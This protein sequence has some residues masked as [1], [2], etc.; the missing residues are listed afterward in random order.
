MR[1][2]GRIFAS[3]EP[4][5][6]VASRDDVGRGGQRPRYLSRRGARRREWMSVSRSQ[7]RTGCSAAWIRVPYRARLSAAGSRHVWAE[8]V[9][10]DIWLVLRPWTAPT[11]SSLAANLTGAW[12]VTVHAEANVPASVQTRGVAQRRFAATVPPHT[13]TRHP[14]DR[15]RLSLRRNRQPGGRARLGIDETRARVEEWEAHSRR[16]KQRHLGTRSMPCTAERRCADAPS[17][18]CRPGRGA[19]RVAHLELVETRK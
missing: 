10:P 12:R 3:L 16:M 13:P 17:S 15:R 5:M 2:A 14:G 7:P 9:D 4:G 11:T 1:A 18:G 19:P 8:I 6:F